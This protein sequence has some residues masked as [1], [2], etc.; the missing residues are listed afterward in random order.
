MNWTIKRV[1]LLGVMAYLGGSYVLNN[2]TRMAEG[3]SIGRIMAGILDLPSAMVLSLILTDTEFDQ[4]SY[5]WPWNQSLSFSVNLLPYAHQRV[6]SFTPSLFV[7]HKP[8]LMFL[9]LTIAWIVKTACPVPSVHRQ[10][11]ISSE[12]ASNSSACEVTLVWY[13]YHYHKHKH[14]NAPSPSQSHLIP[15]FIDAT[16]TKGRAPPLTQKHWHTVVEPLV[17]VWQGMRSPGHYHKQN[18]LV[19]GSVVHPYQSCFRIESESA[20]DPDHHYCPDVYVYCSCNCRR[21]CYRCTS[22]R[23]SHPWYIIHQL[24][25]YASSSPTPA[26]NEHNSTKDMSCTIRRDHHTLSYR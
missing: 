10:V 23:K 7:K 14:K 4:T 13:Y 8:W 25:H 2:I 20:D 6:Y 22:P 24:Q 18:D 12:C 15:C 9:S 5:S 3:G 11:R 26:Y 19:L 1:Q 21:W 17:G 16:T